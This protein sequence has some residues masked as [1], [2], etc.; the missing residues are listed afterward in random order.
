MVP[1]DTTAPPTASEAH[2]FGGALS[3]PLPDSLPG[4]LLG[5]P[6]GPFDLPL[7]FDIVFSAQWL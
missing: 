1:C 3:R 5:Q 4:F 2:F 6:P 7:L